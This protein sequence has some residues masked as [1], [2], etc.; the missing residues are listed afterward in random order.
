MDSIPPTASPPD[1]VS[2]P[3]TR[4]GYIALIGRPNAGKSTLFNSCLGQR[5][6]IVTP[7]PQTT[8]G[9]VLGILSRSG[10]Q[11]IFLDTPGL[12]EA[13]YRLHQ[14]M[15]RQIELAVREADA[16]LLLIDATS[17]TTAANWC[18]LWPWPEAAGGAL[19]KI[20]L[21]PRWRGSPRPW[22]GA[23]V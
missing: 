13:R 16:V 9:R 6:S 4:C 12:L 23:G 1:S 21:L 3:Q 7:K 8:R 10:A 5:L 11:M 18:R 2:D 17:P 15:A 20:D 19:N 22:A 14:L